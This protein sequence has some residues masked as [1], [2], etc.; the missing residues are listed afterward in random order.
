MRTRDTLSNLVLTVIGA[1]ALT[2]GVLLYPITRR[3]SSSPTSSAPLEEGSDAQSTSLGGLGEKRSG[4][5]AF[6]K[7]E[8]L[9]RR[10]RERGL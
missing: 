8:S 4:Q 2:A 7:D 5:I 6:Q 9:L 1:A 3:P 10:L